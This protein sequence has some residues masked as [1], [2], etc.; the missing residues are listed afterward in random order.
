M[1]TNELRSYL[2]AN[3]ESVEEYASAFRAKERVSAAH[4]EA[5]VSQLI[6]WR[7]CKKHQAAWTR[8]GAQ[9]LLHVKTALINGCL[10]RYTGYEQQ[11]AIA[12]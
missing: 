9:A 4:V 10:E 7:F 5:T 6:N 12:A 8:Q 2:Y 3:R 1:L 11:S